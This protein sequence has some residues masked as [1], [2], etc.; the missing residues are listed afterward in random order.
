MNE[1]TNVLKFANLAIRTVRIIDIAKKVI[2][3]AAVGVGCVF[4]VKL[5]RSR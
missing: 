1:F 4:A 3:V 5:W 2:I